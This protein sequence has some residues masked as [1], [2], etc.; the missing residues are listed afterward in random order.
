MSNNICRICGNE[1]S[2]EEYNIKEKM[3]G[4]GEEFE[5]FKC[6]DCGCLQIKKIP[7][8]IQKYYPPNYL[9]DFQSF[10]LKKYFIKKRENA[11]FSGKGTLGKFL[12]KL[13]GIPKEHKWFTKLELNKMNSILEVGCGKGELLNIL[14]LAGFKKLLGIDPFMEKNQVFNEHY[15]L[16]KIN[17]SEIDTIFD[18]VM[19]NH[20]FEHLS[21]PHE[22]FQYLKKIIKKNGQILI[23]IPLVDSYAWETYKTD[24]VQLDPPRHFFLYTVKSIRFLCHK[25]GFRL[26][27]ILYDS[28]GFQFWGSEQCKKQIPFL[29]PNPLF[30]KHN[31]FAFSKK[32]LKIYEQKANELNKNNRGDMASFYLEPF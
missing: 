5:Y 4:T 13:F 14:H 19:F 26:K 16:L 23:R 27:S 20:S 6:M 10:S 29:S 17:L 22:T 11:F 25:Y 15:K 8:N 18:F 30:N 24:W 32:E 2:I 31:N 28:N 3:F 12:I 7:E 9:P 1:N 21:N